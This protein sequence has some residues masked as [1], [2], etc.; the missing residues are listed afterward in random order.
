[1][2]LFKSYKDYLT[3]IRK[4]LVP[5]EVVSKIEEIDIDNLIENGYKTL[6]LDVDN[7]ILPMEEK[8]LTLQ[9][10]NW[11]QKVKDK[12]LTVFF[13]SNNS[14]HKRILK[15]CKQVEING[16]FFSCKPFIHNVVEFAKINNINLTKSA[17]IGDQ[18][19]TDVIIGNW[20]KGYS[21]LTD[22]LDKKLSFIKTL[23]RQIELFL[24]KAL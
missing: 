20:C 1:M 10:A 9:R 22:P 11:V 13:I 14:N 17:F 7:T 12:G 3:I 6:L 18:L 15:V 19:F 8:T 4:I 23:Q 5:N 16:M 24:I 21:I 2:N